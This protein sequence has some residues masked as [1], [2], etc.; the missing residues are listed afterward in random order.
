MPKYKSYTGEVIRVM[1]V[2]AIFGRAFYD[3][4]LGHD[5]LFLRAYKP[6]ARSRYE[7]VFGHNGIEITKDI[8]MDEMLSL[9]N[10]ARAKKF[11]KKR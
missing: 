5:G 11:G 7:L 10:K 9:Q 8:S 1:G 2:M 6:V 3:V 4:Q